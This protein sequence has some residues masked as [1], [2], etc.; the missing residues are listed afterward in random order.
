VSILLPPFEAPTEDAELQMVGLM[1][2]DLLQARLAQV[3]G[4]SIHRSAARASGGSEHPELAG[5]LRRTT[6]SARAHVI[7]ELKERTAERVLQRLMPAF[8]L[9]D[10]DP[11][12]P[13]HLEAYR[14]YLQASGRLLQRAVCDPAVLDLATRSLDLDPDYGPAWMLLGWAHYGRVAACGEGSSHYAEATR[15]IA[16]AQALDPGNTEPL[17]LEVVMLAERGRVEEAYD[18]LG[19]KRKGR[20]NPH[21]EF[22]AA[23]TLTYAG[24]LDDARRALQ[25]ALD[26]NPLYLTDGGWTPNALIY[27]GDRQQ[28]L[29]LLPGTDSPIF[30]WYRGVA[31]LERGNRDRAAQAVAGVFE[32]NPQDTFARLA[33]AL[34]RTLAG[35]PD[36]AR[37]AALALAQHQQAVGSHD[38]EFTFKLAQVL[39]FAGDAPS[40]LQQLDRAVEQGFTC[41]RCVESSPLLDPVRTLDRYASVLAAA[42]ERHEAFGRRFGLAQDR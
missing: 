22:G 40:A 13:R 16:R 3:D 1:T 9:P 19:D 10:A 38:G 36:E 30:Q 12:R 26:L 8:E 4:V 7:L 37:T 15:A 27:L 31:E 42:Q 24:Y 5:S 23:Y 17:L 33:L 25:R 35:H 29:S 20:P 34:S 21:V 39:A 14:L 11:A 6:D 2:A 32:R 28:F 18:R 41:P